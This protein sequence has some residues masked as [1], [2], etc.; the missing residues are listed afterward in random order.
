MYVNFLSIEQKGDPYTLDCMYPALYAQRR[1]NT[2]WSVTITAHAHV[3]ILQ[4]LIDMDVSLYYMR[5]RCIR[6]G[7]T[8][9]S[10]VYLCWQ[11]ALC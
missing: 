3:C 9:I 6:N 8:D 10:T 5:S 1:A 2:I 11:L 7:D 4:P